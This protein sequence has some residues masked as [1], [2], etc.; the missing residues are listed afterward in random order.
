M[1]RIMWFE[2]NVGLLL[3]SRVNVIVIEVLL[4]TTFSCQSNHL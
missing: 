3:T 4:L 2:E 1:L